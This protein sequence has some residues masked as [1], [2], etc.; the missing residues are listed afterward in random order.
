[1]KKIAC[2]TLIVLLSTLGAAANAAEFVET[3]EFAVDEWRPI[4]E[5]DGPVTLH[6]IRVDRKEDRLTK[7][8]L[9]R[10]YN[11]EY[12]EPV[13]IQLEYSNES[14][15]K[16]RARIGVRWLDEDGTVIDGFSANETLQKKSAKKIVQASVSTLKYGISR[17]RTLE[18]E[19][20]F[21]P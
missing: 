20:R 9:V 7:S 12:L 1:M 15:R 19:I 6:R 5:S 3:Y 4:E 17:A 14:S 8:A 13:R 11:Q 10:P 21:E 2:I 16:W 18:V